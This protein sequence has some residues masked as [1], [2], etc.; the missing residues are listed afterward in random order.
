M[1]PTRLLLL[2]LGLALF[3]AACVASPP[4]SWP[5]LSANNDT[6]F[7]AYNNQVIA[8]NLSDGKQR[9]AFP[10]SP[11]GELFFAEPGVSDEIIVVGSEGTL[12]QFH[13]ALFGLDPATGAQKWCL[14]LDSRARDRLTT[15]TAPCPLI[16]GG[17]EATFFGLVMPPVDNRVIGGVVVRDGIAY[18]GL[19]NNQVIAVDALTGE[20]QWTSPVTEHPIWTA[21]LVDDLTIYVASLDHSLYAL[22]R[23]DGS[24]KWNV[25]LGASLGG[26]PALVDGVLYAGTFGNKVVALRAADGSEL[27]RSDATN[28]VWGGPAVRAGVVYFA[29]LNGAVFAVNAAT[30]QEQ[31]QQTPGDKIRSTPALF[32]DS[33][34]IG[35]RSSNLFALNAAT[36]SSQWTQAIPGGGHIY[37]APLVIAERDLV[38]AAVYQGS[39]LLVAYTPTGAFKWAFAP[40][41]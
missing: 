6:A 41:R 30:G 4:N 17:A 27:W 25:D 28:W 22:N 16:P 2:G 35:D 36:G 14:A 9:W 24:L 37:S 33:L 29:D 20:H 32:N 11:G 31:W 26:T 12:G 8:V 7:V 39:N 34:F 3:T 19:A 21:P 23:R 18:A 13:G 1:K 15:A 10:P 5:G 40:S 38:L